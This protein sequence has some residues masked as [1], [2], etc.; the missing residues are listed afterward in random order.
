MSLDQNKTINETN[1]NDD[2]KNDSN[3]NNFLTQLKDKINSI[4]N[5]EEL[6]LEINEEKE[7]KII[8]F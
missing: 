8:I 2:N 1:N 7:S 3:Q 4:E 6:Y 5:K